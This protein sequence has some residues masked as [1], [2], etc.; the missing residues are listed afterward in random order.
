MGTLAKGRAVGVIPLPSGLYRD[1]KQKLRPKSAGCGDAE[2]S[3]PL[4]VG[5][6][7]SRQNGLL[8]SGPTEDKQAEGS[9]AGS[10]LKFDYQATRSPP[11]P[12]SRLC[13]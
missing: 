13:T 1:M 5:D 2:S 9:R 8:I 11:G 7:D 12:K 10:G 3:D 6:G 4:Y